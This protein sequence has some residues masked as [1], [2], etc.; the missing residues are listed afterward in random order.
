MRCCYLIEFIKVIW[1]TD[2]WVIKAG[3]DN[4]VIEF[5]Y[6][7]HYLIVELIKVIEVLWF[8]ENDMKV[9]INV[10]IKIT[11]RFFSFFFLFFN[12][13]LY[14]LLF[15]YLYY[16]YIYF[17]YIKLVSTRFFY[18]TPYFFYTLITVFMVCKSSYI[19]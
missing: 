3:T 17:F 16:I 13:L 8:G 2:N 19:L 6:K 1:G 15:V 14:M 18:W 9:E 4:W 5:I 12:K 11:T 7:S 10:F